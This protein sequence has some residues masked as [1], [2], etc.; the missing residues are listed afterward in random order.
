MWWNSAMVG[1]MPFATAR[2]SWC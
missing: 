2:A 1:A